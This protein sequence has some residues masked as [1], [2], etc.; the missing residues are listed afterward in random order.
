MSYVL[1]RKAA[2]EVADAVAFYTKE[3]G[4]AVAANFIAEFERAA[5]MISVN[6]GLGTPT[7][8]GRRIFPLRRFPYSLIFRPFEQNVKIIVVAHQHR[9][10]SYWR[11]RE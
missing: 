8:S 11:D 6:R 10:P 1:T 2:Q 7:S 3:A 4:S 5:K 9:R